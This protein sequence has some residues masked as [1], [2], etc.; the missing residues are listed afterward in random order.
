MLSVLQ[1]KFVLKSNDYADI[2][3]ILLL[4]L[5]FSNRRVSFVVSETLDEP[6]TFLCQIV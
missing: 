1:T 5:P 4:L 3:F 2:Q 6:R